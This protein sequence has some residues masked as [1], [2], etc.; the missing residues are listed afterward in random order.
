MIETHLSCN[1]RF[2]CGT[3]RDWSPVETLELKVV[4]FIYSCNYLLAMNERAD[5]YTS[6]AG[7]LFMH[8]C[9]SLLKK[10]KYKIAH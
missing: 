1:R 6:S 2:A 8:H 3:S 10:S 9:P 7:I 4:Q 5:F